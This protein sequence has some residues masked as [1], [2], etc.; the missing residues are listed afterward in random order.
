MAE[1]LFGDRSPDTTKL[2]DPQRQMKRVSGGPPCVI[3]GDTML[4]MPAS[5]YEGRRS[6]AWALSTGNHSLIHGFLPPNSDTP[7]HTHHGE[8]LS[9][10][11]SQHVGGAQ[12]SRCDG[13]VRFL[14]ENIDLTTLRN[15]FSR[16]DGEVLGEF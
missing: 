8:V 12:F 15:L 14:S 1:T 10:P 4:T 11:R 3:D 13:S 2:D 6:G 16:N 9:G 5:R 7:D